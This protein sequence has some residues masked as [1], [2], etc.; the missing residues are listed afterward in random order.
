MLVR[1]LQDGT[2][3]WEIGVAMWDDTNEIYSRSVDDVLNYSVPEYVNYINQNYEK[4]SE[5]FQSYWISITTPSEFILNVGQF[6]CITDEVAK[7]LKFYKITAAVAEAQL[8]IPIKR[9]E[10]YQNVIVLGRATQADIHVA[11]AQTSSM[12]SKEITGAD[13]ESKNAVLTSLQRAR[14]SAAYQYAC[15]DTYGWFQSMHAMID[16]KQIGQ[17]SFIQTLGRS[18]YFIFIHNLL[19]K[20]KINTMESQDYITFAMNARQLQQFLGNATIKFYTMDIE[21]NQI[22]AY[23]EAL[24]FALSKTTYKMKCEFVVMERVSGSAKAIGWEHLPSHWV[25][26][27]NYDGTFRS[28]QKNDHMTDRDEDTVSEAKSDHIT[29][30]DLNVPTQRSTPSSLINPT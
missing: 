7:H 28:D 24:D 4:F 23:V 18:A 2:T 3:K 21:R 14:L 22:S 5:K 26:I 8:R 1:N 15:W 30:E 12:D 13:I 19:V 16:W 10:F 20:Y 17:T 27:L 11:T 9:K 25:E 29:D 6:I